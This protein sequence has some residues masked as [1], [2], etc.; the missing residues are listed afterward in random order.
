MC[1]DSSIIRLHTHQLYR[2]STLI[3]I[4]DVLPVRLW[5][6]MSLFHRW[7]EEVQWSICTLTDQQWGIKRRLNRSRPWRLSTRWRA[8]V[9]LQLVVAERWVWLSK[10][11]HSHVLVV[12]A[13]NAHSFVMSE[14]LVH[15][16]QLKL[17]NAHKGIERSFLYNIFSKN[18]WFLWFVWSMIT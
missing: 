1:D 13:I 2:L 15:W 14:T 3:H 17:P 9:I 10:F 8:C 4:I 18:R 12:P 7:C 11:I 16:K 5:G 6:L